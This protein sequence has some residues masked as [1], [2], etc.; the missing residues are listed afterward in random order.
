MET[1][2]KQ[3]KLLALDGGGI[4]GVLSLGILAAIEKTVG[5]PLAEYFDY[6]AGTST[7]AIIAAGLSKGLS[8][9]ELE[10]FY[11]NFGTQ[12]FEERFLLQ[13]YKSLYTSDP[14]K[15]QLQITFGQDTTLGS[16]DL[17]TL[18]LVVTRNWSTDS[19]WPVSSNP[20]AIYNNA[21]L[22]NCNLRIP[23]WQLV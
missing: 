12:M 23:L 19:P 9:Q 2:S 20:A 5:R 8:V 4:R 3:R 21:A 22:R 17:K 7:G 15:K 1:Q 16:E 10:A 14:L 13:R 6:I 11:R 18:L